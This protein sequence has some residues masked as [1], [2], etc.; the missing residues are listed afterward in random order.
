MVVATATNR[1]R[2]HTPQMLQR[3]TAKMELTTVGS[4]LTSI[5]QIPPPIHMDGME[6]NI[7]EIALTIHTVQ[8]ILIPGLNTMWNHSVRLHRKTNE[9]LVLTA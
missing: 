9:A 3:Y 1:G 8:A 2:I 6:V 5:M 4:A 7:R